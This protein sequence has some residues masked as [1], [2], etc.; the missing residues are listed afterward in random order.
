MIG[1][2]DILPLILYINILCMHIFNLPACEN[3]YFVLI[4]ANF[5]RRGAGDP[6]KCWEKRESKAWM[7][8]NDV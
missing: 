6:V 4:R 5:W 2:I 3:S 1:I 8:V 7:S